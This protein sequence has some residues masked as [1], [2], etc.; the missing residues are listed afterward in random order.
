M[1]VRVR[2]RRVRVEGCDSVS[3]GWVVRS[4]QVCNID[5]YILLPSFRSSESMFQSV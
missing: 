4:V 1:R 2:G 3:L 5:L